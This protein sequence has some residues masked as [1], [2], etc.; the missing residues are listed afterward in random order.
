[1]AS[2][3]SPSKVGQATRVGSS[4]SPEERVGRGQTHFH[5]SS[6][7]RRR[8]EPRVGA[9]LLRDYPKFTPNATYTVIVK[10]L[11]LA[12]SEVGNTRPVKS[13]SLCLY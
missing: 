13:H 9:R 1:M 5:K 4:R 12:I 3:R 10:R 2:R 7:N 11:P 6:H 8:R